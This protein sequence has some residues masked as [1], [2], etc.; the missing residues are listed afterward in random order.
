MGLLLLSQFV[1]VKNKQLIR[2]KVKIM[3]NVNFYFFG[4][5]SVGFLTLRVAA[6]FR[7]N[8]SEPTLLR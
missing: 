7:E 6:N 4:G 1:A 3:K 8:F 5:N 2:I